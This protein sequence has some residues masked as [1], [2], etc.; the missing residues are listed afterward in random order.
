MTE[1]QIKKTEAEDA[2]VSTVSNTCVTYPIV[3]A[4][5]GADEMLGLNREWK[6]INPIQGIFLTDIFAPCKSEVG[7]IPEISRKVSEDFNLLNAFLR[8]HGF[9]IQLQPF[10]KSRSEF[11]VVS[12]LKL[13]VKWLE[14][15]VIARITTP[16]GEFPAVCLT[17]KKH[18]VLIL[19]TAEYPN[20][21]AKISTQSGDV[22][23][24]TV[25]DRSLEGFDLVAKV[26]KLSSNLAQDPSFDRVRFPMVDLNHK[27][28]ISWLKG[29]PTTD[30]KGLPWFIAQALQ[31]TKLQ[32][33]E[34]GA[35]VESAVA[36][37]VL[38]G[39]IEMPKEE[40]IIDK[41]F[42]MWITRKG[43]SK[44]LFAGYVASDCWKDPGRSL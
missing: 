27:V 42:F 23:F 28:D 36:I 33:N 39:C 15:G 25:A 31:Q 22:V 2:K 44:P 20:P 32:M 30:E 21:V 6:A 43:L 3:S 41:P 18:K 8:E 16:H 1:T 38:R 12:I 29:M 4:V 17:K 9:D 5:D 7:K 24:M 11:G 37:S 26:E 19:K 35:K 14:K 10:D 13:I 40:L 34:V